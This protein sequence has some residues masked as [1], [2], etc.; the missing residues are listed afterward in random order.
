M[1][2]EDMEDQDE[3][4]ERLSSLG[5]ISPDDLRLVMKVLTSGERKKSEL[6]PSLL[7][8]LNFRISYDLV[9]SLR[10]M[11]KTSAALSK[12]LVWLTVLLLLFTVALL[13]EPFVAHFLH[14]QGT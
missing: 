9:Q 6:Q 14:W 12:K 3:L 5:H 7:A 1:N 8:A 10:K 2:E 11:D 13:A 4:E